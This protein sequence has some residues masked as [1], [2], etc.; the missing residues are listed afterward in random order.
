MGESRTQ[1][2]LARKFRQSQTDAEQVLWARLKNKQ[3]ESVKFRR[4]QPLG[5]YIVD[6]VSF[7]RRIIVEVDGGHHNE[8]EAKKRDEKRVAWLKENG[9]Q[10]LRFWNNEVLTNMEGVLEKI[11]EALK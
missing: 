6:F 11:Q 1:I 4:Q 3:L 9:Y 2:A 5:L 10:V 7:E 8:L